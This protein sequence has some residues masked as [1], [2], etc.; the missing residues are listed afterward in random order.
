MAEPGF[1][2][3]FHFESTPYPLYLR[4]SIIKY[5]CWSHSTISLHSWKNSRRAWRFQQ[6]IWPEEIS[7]NQPIQDSRRLGDEFN[8]MIPFDTSSVSWWQN[9]DFVLEYAN[10]KILQDNDDR[11]SN[12]PYYIVAAGIFVSELLRHRHL[13]G[14]SQ[15]MKFFWKR[16]GWIDKVRAI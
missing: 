2:D 7:S 10:F 6:A 15:W 1:L 12:A 16:S 4:L 8:W 5:T 9:P 3:I 11:R 14:V 13:Y